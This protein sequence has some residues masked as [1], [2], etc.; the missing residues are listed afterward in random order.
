VTDSVLFNPEEPVSIDLYRAMKYK[1]SKYDIVLQSG[2]IIFIPE[3]N[4]IVSVTGNLQS[5]LKIYFD[6]D[7]TKLSYYIDKAG[8]F[9]LKPWRERIYV[10]YANGRSRRTKNLGFFHFYPKVGEGSTVTVPF[11]P[12]PT[13]PL[14]GLTAALIKAAVPIFT[15]LIISKFIK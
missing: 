1:N 13:N 5:P 10:T 9:G 12:K 8:G 6:K 2:D 14:Q 15:A 3:I 7:H 4:P 11:K